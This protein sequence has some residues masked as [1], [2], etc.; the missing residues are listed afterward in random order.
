MTFKINAKT[1]SVTEIANRWALMG[2][3]ICGLFLSVAYLVKGFILKNIYVTPAVMIALALLVPPAICLWIL[4]KNKETLVIRR[5]API[6]YGIAL[7]IIMT[8]S[9]TPLTFLYSIPIL[10][11]LLSYNK[12][13]LINLTA[14]VLFVESCIAYVYCTKISESWTMTTDEKL[15]YFIASSVICV[16]AC[17]STLITEATTKAQIAREAEDKQ[18]IQDIVTATTHAV[19]DI[20][21]NITNVTAQVSNVS[22]S[23]NAIDTAISEIIAG[24][25]TIRDIIEVQVH[26]MQTI[27]DKTRNVLQDATNI[28]EAAS[29]ANDTFN[30]V[31]REMTTL[32]T[33]TN[34]IKETAGSTTENVEQLNAVVIN[35]SEVVDI[36]SDIASQI[37]LLSL[38]ASIEAARAGDSGRGFAVVADEIGKLASQTDTATKDVYAKITT[39]KDEFGTVKTSIDSFVELSEKQE[40]SI[41]STISHF[42]KCKSAMTEI[43]TLADKQKAAVSDLSQASTK[44]SDSTQ[45]L[46]AI[47]EETLA[48]AMS[49]GDIVKNSNENLD[50]TARNTEHISADIAEL[51]QRLS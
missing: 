21:A 25:E 2:W 20:S 12:A 14:S 5:V 17:V 32:T 6:S 16:F 27:T 4:I 42:D 28:N 47:E 35:V 22:Q 19:A 29:D 7:Y 10:V 23:S 36:I 40:S 50:A 11:V 44:V 37:K 33:L 13:K 8:T 41:T 45:D 51:N 24:M 34:N 31:A 1:M 39:L 43:V 3:A 15:V 26:E 30:L 9:K 48:N 46:C 18:R 38:N 49:T